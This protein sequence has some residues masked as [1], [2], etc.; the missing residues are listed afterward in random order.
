MVGGNVA[1][2]FVCRVSKMIDDEG[3]GYNT[4]LIGDQFWMQENLNIGTAINSLT[5]KSGFEIKGSDLFIND[6]NRGLIIKN[7]NGLCFRL[8]LDGEGNII[9]QKIDCPN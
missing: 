8:I 5:P 7:F 2:A 4:V 1:L 3:N 9:A 6:E